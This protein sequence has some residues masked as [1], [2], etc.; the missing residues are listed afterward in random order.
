MLIVAQLVKNVPSSL[1]PEGPLLCSQEP[2]TGHVSQ[3]HIIR[4]LSNYF[5][6]I[7][8]SLRRSSKCSLAV[9]RVPE[10][11]HLQVFWTC[12][13]PAVLR[14]ENATGW[15]K[16]KPAALNFLIGSPTEVLYLFIFQNH[17]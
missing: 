17:K 14:R 16:S 8:S 15:T 11:S 1:E 12:L 5:N 2:A 10:E 6:V 4:F 7:R 3:A 13:S 9:L